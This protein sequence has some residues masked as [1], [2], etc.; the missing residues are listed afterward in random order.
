MLLY[1]VYVKHWPTWFSVQPQ[2]DV[3]LYIDAAHWSCTPCTQQVRWLY[4]DRKHVACI[5]SPFTGTVSLVC[6]LYR[7]FLVKHQEDRWRS[8]SS[9]PHAAQWSFSCRF[10]IDITLVLYTVRLRVSDLGVLV[11]VR[12][13]WRFSRL[14]HMQIRMVTTPV[15]CA[16]HGRKLQL[17]HHIHFEHTFMETNGISLP[18]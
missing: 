3:V 11:G 10:S 2:T 5:L 16:L 7:L 12:A 18:W 15:E 6:M 4:M 1:W 17:R 13:T 8:L 14:N 9:R